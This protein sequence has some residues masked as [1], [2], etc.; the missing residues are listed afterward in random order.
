MRIARALLALAAVAVVIAAAALFWLSRPVSVAA[1]DLPGHQPDPANG[2]FVFWASGCASC[3]IA[4]G[5]DQRTLLAGGVEL[6]TPYGVFRAPNISPDPEHGIGGWS[7]AQFVSAVKY[8]TAPDG[9]HYYPAFPYASYHKMR[10]EDV[11]DLKAFLDTLEPSDND[12]AGNVLSFPY[13]IRR[14]L[15]LWKLRYLSED[16]VVEDLPDDPAVRHGQYLVEA[17]GHC[18]ECH[19]A[20]D[21]AGGMLPSIW[22]AGAPNP[23]G[24]GMVPNITPHP[25]GLADWSEGDIAYAL[26]TGLTPEFDSLGGSMAEVV[27]NQSRL[28]DDDRRAIAAYLKAIPARTPEDR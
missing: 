1:E 18:G 11:M 14:G 24:E 28:A 25:Q 10:V 2:E 27:R 21:G 20:R 16:P 8:G 22:L 13:N 15:G 6:E 4:P 19:T 17:M 7:M 12:V 9:H 23:E 5:S 3:H 26:E